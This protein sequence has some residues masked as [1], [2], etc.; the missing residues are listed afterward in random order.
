MIAF[1][2][3]GCIGIGIFAGVLL[4]AAAIQHAED[5]SRDDE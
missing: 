4:V 5:N 2:A 1:I 3:F